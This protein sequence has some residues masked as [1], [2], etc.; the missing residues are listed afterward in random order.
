MGGD[1]P[2]AGATAEGKPKAKAKAPNSRKSRGKTPAA[3]TDGNPFAAKRKAAAK[4]RGKAAAKK[5]VDSNGNAIGT[6]GPPTKKRKASGARAGKKVIETLAH[7]KSEDSDEGFAS[8]CSAGAM[9]GDGKEGDGEGYTMVVE[10]YDAPEGDE[11]QLA[12]QVELEEEIN[13]HTAVETL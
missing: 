6:E 3:D 7:I 10:E 1:K 11:G 12:A 9:K 8:A 5:E 13:G 4:P 2:A